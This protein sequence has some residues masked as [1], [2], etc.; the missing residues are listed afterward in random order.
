MG[1]FFVEQKDEIKMGDTPSLVRLLKGDPLDPAQPGWGGHYVRAW[2]R[3]FRRF[4]RMTTQADRIE[5]FGILELMLPMDN[6][7][8]TQPQ[9][10]LI[11]D[12]QKLPGTVINDDTMCFRFSPK[13]NKGFTF[14]IQSN[15]PALDGLAGGITA[16]LPSPDRVQHPSETHPNWWT[17]DPTLEIAEGPHHGAKT[18]SRWREEFLTDFAQRMLRCQSRV[19]TQ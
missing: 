14:K 16:I 15:V 4:E 8:P 2:D 9:A 6:E 5:I 12:N 13:S 18:V 1:D 19:S 3:P 17:D 11:V 10:F 7:I